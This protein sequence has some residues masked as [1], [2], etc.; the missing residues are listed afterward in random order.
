MV[1]QTLQLLEQ[2]F[3]IHS[4][5]HNADI[6]PEVLRSKVFFIGKTYDELSIVCD[7]SINIASNE[8]EHGWAALEFVGP[9]GFSMTGI[10]ANLAAV[11]AK[12]KISIFSISTFETDYILLKRN[13]VQNAISEL[14]SAGYKIL[15]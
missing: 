5:D 1:T 4:L 3:T 7:D 8:Q 12:A 13:H 14:R 11:L 6:P 9:L 2:T 10:L 15:T